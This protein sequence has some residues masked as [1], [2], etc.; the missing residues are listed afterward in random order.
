MTSKH[1]NNERLCQSNHETE[2]KVCSLTEMNEIVSNKL[3][4]PQHTALYR[5]AKEGY[6]A[7]S[8][9]NVLSSLSR[10]ESRSTMVIQKVKFEPP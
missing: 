3:K 9:A 7:L 6:C 1:I 4:H 2:S 10:G 8:A 5:P